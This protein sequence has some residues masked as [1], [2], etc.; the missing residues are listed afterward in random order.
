MRKQCKT[1]ST[2]RIYL[3]C[4]KTFFLLPYLIPRFIY[5][6]KHKPASEGTR[7]LAGYAW[8]FTSIVFA[9][10]GMRI[11]W[12][13]CPLGFFVLLPLAIIHM[14]RADEGDDC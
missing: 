11:H 13:L 9:I 14:A 2:W 5:D 7:W 12:I 1:P 8:M 4:V 6:N 3:E 10:F